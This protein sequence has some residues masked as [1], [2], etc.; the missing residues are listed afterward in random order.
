[1]RSQPAEWPSYHP[2]SHALARNQPSLSVIAS[3]HETKAVFRHNQGLHVL[4][5]GFPSGEIGPKIPEELIFRVPN[6]FVS[7]HMN[8]L[9]NPRNTWPTAHEEELCPGNGRWQ[10]RA[11]SK[12]SDGQMYGHG[13][14]PGI[15]LAAVGGFFLVATHD[16]KVMGL[17]ENKVFSGVHSP[18]QLVIS[19]VVGFTIGVGSHICC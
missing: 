6:W 5:V 2:L 7:P 13:R 9:K 3:R 17:G 14:G 15:G 11:D 4:H 8:R 1:M 16:R 19:F 10:I 18:F 12:G